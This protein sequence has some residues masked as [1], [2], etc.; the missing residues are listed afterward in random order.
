M[1]LIFVGIGGAL[2]S[3]VR[4][5]LGKV[6]AQKSRSDFPVNTFLINI[7]G[8]IL[9]GAFIGMDISGSVYFLIADGFLGAYTTF[10]TFMYEGFQLFGENERK[11]AFVY[12]VASLVIG[13]IGYIIGYELSHRLVSIQ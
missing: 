2:G 9:L 8:A 6:I 7:T 12:I 1:D 11:N 3:I 13:I 4:Y 10:S 5:K